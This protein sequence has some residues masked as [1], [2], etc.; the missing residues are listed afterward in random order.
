MNVYLKSVGC[1]LN[2]S[3]IETLARQFA[4]RGHRVVSAPEKAHLCVLNSCVVTH[5]AARKSRQAVRRLRRRNPRAR[6]V[7]TGCYAEVAPDDLNADDIVGNADKERLAEHLLSKSAAP[8]LPLPFLPR[9]LLP[10]G[11]RRAFVKIQDGCDNHCTYCIIRIARGPQRSRSRAQ[12]LAEVQARV[13]TGYREVV[14]TGVHIGAYGHDRGQAPVDSLWDL[15]EAIL[16]QTDICRLRLSSIEP[17]DVATDVF[18][19][20]KDRRLCRHLHLPLQSGSDEILRRMGRRYTA[21]EFAR[22]VEM[23]RSAIPG[24][25]ITTDVIVG[26]PGE[27]EAHFAQSL[28]LVESIGFARTHVFPYSVRPGT[29][30]ASLPNHIPPSEKRARAAQ[31]RA[32]AH[33]TATQFQRQFINQVVDVLWESRHNGQWRG[34]TDNYLRVTAQSDD[35]L[36][37]TITPVRLSAGTDGALHGILLEQ[38]AQSAKDVQ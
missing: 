4:S 3:E 7:A 25:A 21:A 11:R 12:V 8:T 18:E 1:K 9:S 29:A 38:P 30:A 16:S 33:H 28:A 27:T 6:I 10:Q 36:A 13:E 22:T 34:L 37:Q 17:W 20:W 23:A 2:Q 35:N 26:F 14:L 5:V 32:V 19:L 24:V 31:M 15:I